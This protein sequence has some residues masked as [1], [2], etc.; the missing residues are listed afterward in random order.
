MGEVIEYSKME[1]IFYDP[2]NKKTEDY[3]AGRFG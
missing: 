1:E 3:I 2:K